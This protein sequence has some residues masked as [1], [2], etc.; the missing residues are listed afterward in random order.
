MYTTPCPPDHFDDTVSCPHC[1]RPVCVASHCLRYSQ[2]FS[3]RFTGPRWLY[4]AVCGDEEE[5]GHPYPC[6]K[7]LGFE[8]RVMAAA[9]RKNDRNRP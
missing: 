3:S 9:E 2:H 5:G 4:A 1:E 8:G 6:K 7:C